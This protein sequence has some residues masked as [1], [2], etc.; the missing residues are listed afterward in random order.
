LILHL[1][2]EKRMDRKIVEEKENIH[3][4]NFLFTNLFFYD[5]ERSIYITGPKFSPLA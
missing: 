2:I 1:F 5:I 3:N 4:V